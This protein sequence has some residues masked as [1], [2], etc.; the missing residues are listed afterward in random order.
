MRSTH[1]FPLTIVVPAVM[2]VAL[3]ACESKDSPTAGPELR[4]RQFLETLVQ[5][6]ANQSRLDELSPPPRTEPTAPL[7]VALDLLNTRYRQGATLRYRAGDAIA[8]PDGTAR[9]VV[10]VQFDTTGGRDRVQFSVDLRADNKVWR[11]ERL[12][13]AD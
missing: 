7:R 1:P 3:S 4:A 11:V 12:N 8:R 2:A 9:V 13:L 5:E 10:A 6:P